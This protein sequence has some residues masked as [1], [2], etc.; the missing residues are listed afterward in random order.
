MQTNFICFLMD[1]LNVVYTASKWDEIKCFTVQYPHPVCHVAG[2]QFH[3]L[4]STR[5]N[6]AVDVLKKCCQSAFKCC[7]HNPN[8]NFRFSNF[9]Q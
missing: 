4:L 5:T 6:L 2:R 1:L 7:Y 8:L 9:K 3:V